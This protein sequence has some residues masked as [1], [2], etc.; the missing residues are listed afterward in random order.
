MIHGCGDP[1]VLST[2][3][4]RLSGATIAVLADARSGARSGTE[5]RARTGADARRS[6]ATATDGHDERAAAGEA[7]PARL[8]AAGA[9]AGAVHLARPAPGSMPWPS[10]RSDVISQSLQ[11]P[12]ACQLW[13]GNA[14]SIRCKGSRNGG[15]SLQI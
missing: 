8:A 12:R 15:A 9:G 10:P 13:P 11:S 3:Y 1:M 6:T 2:S 4:N 5:A 14:A 7:R